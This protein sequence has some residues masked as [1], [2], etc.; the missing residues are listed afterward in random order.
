MSRPIKDSL[1]FFYFPTDFFT[2]REIR[3]LV[4]GSNGKGGFGGKGALV[5]I[6]MLS[7]LHR[8][9][10][11]FLRW[12]DEYAQDI[13]DTL[14]DGF[15]SG[16]VFEVKKRCLE[17][18]LFEKDLFDQH[19]ILT[20]K[21]IQE[22]FLSVKEKSGKRSYKPEDI[23]RAEYISDGFAEL[24]GEKQGITENHNEIPSNPTKRKLKETKE[25]ET[26]KERGV[27]NASDFLP[28]GKKLPTDTKPK[29]ENQPVI[30]ENLKT[31]LFAAAWSD[32]QQHRK[33]KRAKLTPKCAQSQ[34]EKLAAMGEQRAVETIRHCITNGWTGL[35]E[36]QGAAK[37]T[38]GS[39]AQD[40]KTLDVTGGL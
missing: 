22:F 20:S 33:E 6:C 30:P 12:D 39:W 40:L 8:E 26:K 3:R 11:Y 25:K 2:R 38:K 15:T 10:G 1:D 14:G 17:I 32:W 19:K 21:S 9:N 13:A 23:M 37:K 31:D 16:L 5:F 29:P 34:L 27:F 36:P 18:G 24:Y 4:N 28:Q 7:E 35:F